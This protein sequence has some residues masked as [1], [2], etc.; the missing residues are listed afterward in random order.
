MVDDQALKEWFCR[1]VLPLERPLLAFIRRNWRD[2]A[3]VVDLRQD[4]YERVLLGARHGLPAGAGQF[5]YTVARNHLINRA[6]RARI[7]SFDV[8]ADLDAIS[9]NDVLDP[10]RQLLAREELHRIQL[11]LEKLPPRCRE[12]VLLRKI[13]GLSTRETANELGIGIDTVE[14]QM[15]LGMRALANFMLGGSA[16]VQRSRVPG[17]LARRP[18]R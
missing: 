10:E 17:L 11:G 7:V 8:V 9:G 12:V 18:A 6:K 15:T 4:I 2:P 1:E 16:K 13:S 3:D 5:V 14:K